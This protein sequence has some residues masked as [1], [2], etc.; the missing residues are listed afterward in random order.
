LLKIRTWGIEWK[1]IINKIKE[2]VAWQWANAKMDKKNL[3]IMRQTVNISK[4]D[5]EDYNLAMF[6]H[7]MDFF[8]ERASFK[9]PMKIIY[10]MLWLLK[11]M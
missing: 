2:W 8:N 10:V 1:R 5:M 7:V 11:Q 4:D 3:F 6:T 9:K